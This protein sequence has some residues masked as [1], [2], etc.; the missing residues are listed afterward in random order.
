MAFVHWNL[1][2]YRPGNSGTFLMI[3]I[4]G[5]R[6]LDSV[7]FLFGLIPALLLRNLLAALSWFLPALLSRLIPAL[8]LTIDS[9]TFSFCDS[10]T[11]PLYNSATLLNSGGRAFLLI[12]GAALTLS[13]A[14]T[15][16]LIPIFSNWFANIVA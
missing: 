10:F 13:G 1:T 9:V 12:S 16:F 8:L 7:A 3:F 14:V 6:N 15:L 4:I 2:A 5:I 11:F